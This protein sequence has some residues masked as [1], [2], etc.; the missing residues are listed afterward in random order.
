MLPLSAPVMLS[1]LDT[2][3]A[4]G[5]AAPESFV[6]CVNDGSRDATWEV[7]NRLHAADKRVKGIS[8][9]TT[10]GNRTPF[11]P[12][13]TPCATCAMQPSALTPTFR[14]LPRL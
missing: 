9:A 13:S 8:L 1:I 11:W 4:K 12:A 3:T 14:I 7:I 2:L 5:L 6:L 10:A